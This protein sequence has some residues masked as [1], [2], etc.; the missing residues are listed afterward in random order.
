MKHIKIEIMTQETLHGFIADAQGW[1]KRFKTELDTAKP[2]D[3]V[4]LNERFQYQMGRFN[5]LT[6]VHYSM[7][8]EPYTKRA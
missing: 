1:A 7:F 3:K 4:W 2:E 8:N 6:K 5:A